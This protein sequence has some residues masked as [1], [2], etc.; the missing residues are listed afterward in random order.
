MTTFLR[1]WLAHV[2]STAPAV[3]PAGEMHILVVDDQASACLYADRVL[4]LAG[5]R[6][7]VASSGFEAIRKAKAMPRVDVL[8][9]DLLM[10]GMNGDELAR[11]LRERDTQLKVLYVTGLSGRLFRERVALGDGDALLEKPFSMTALEHAFSTLTAGE[12]A[13]QARGPA[14]A[15]APA[16]WM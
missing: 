4:R 12:L 10:P 13:R 5:Y 14:H 3:S 15:A 6:A 9:T 2:L 8:V 7:V 1:T 11:D 16:L